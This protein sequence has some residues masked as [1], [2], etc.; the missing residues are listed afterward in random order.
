M[1]KRSKVI[2]GTSNFRPAIM[3]VTPA[4]VNLDPYSDFRVQWGDAGSHTIDLSPRQL[5]RMRNEKRFATRQT[6]R[7]ATAACQYQDKSPR[8]TGGDLEGARGRAQPAPVVGV[9]PPVAVLPRHVQQCARNG[10]RGWSIWMWRRDQPNLKTRVAYTCKSWRCEGECARAAAAQLFARLKEAVERHPAEEWSF[11]VLTLDRDGYYSGKPWPNADVAYK[12][13]GHMS[14]RF[15][16]RMRRFCERMGWGSFGSDWAQVVEAHRSGWPHVNLL[17]RNKGLAKYLADEQKTRLDNGASDMS[18]RLIQNDILQHAIDCDWGTHSTAEA[19]KDRG[20]MAGYLTKLA[21]QAHNHI[22]ELAKI[23]QA[24]TN[25]PLKF[26][27]LRSGVGFLPKVKKNL[28]WTGGLVRRYYDPEFGYVAQAFRGKKHKPTAQHNEELC[29]CEHIEG[30]AFV[31]ELVDEA[32]A[33]REHK[34][35]RPG[36]DYGLPSVTRWSGGKQVSAAREPSGDLFPQSSP[37]D[38]SHFGVRKCKSEKRAM[39]G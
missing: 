31:D 17:I 5:W 22:G 23:T 33:A 20:A 4:P 29:Q 21:A 24:P 15:L 27:R 28:Q 32:R 16:K 8:P 13:L 38:L 35:L 14:E 25:A 19:V 10:G 39:T 37:A 26:R 30:V 1:S 6:V 7:L 3:P 34:R 12:S 2:A 9:G 11:W 36:I 18:S